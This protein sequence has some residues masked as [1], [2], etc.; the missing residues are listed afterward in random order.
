MQGPLPM[1]T[2]VTKLGWYITVWNTGG[3]NILGNTVSSYLYTFFQADREKLTVRIQNAGTEVV[4]AK[5]GAVSK[6]VNGKVAQL[7]F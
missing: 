1:T 7:V 2:I 5:A 4:E 3:F 6:T